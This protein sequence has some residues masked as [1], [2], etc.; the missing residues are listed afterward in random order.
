MHV[1]N[2]APVRTG[3][4][5]KVRDYAEGRVYCLVYKHKTDRELRVVGVYA[6]T[7][8]ELGKG[9]TAREAWTKLA[10]SDERRTLQAIVGLGDTG[11]AYRLAD[12]ALE[13]HRYV[14]VAYRKLTMD[15]AG[16]WRR[17]VVRG[18]RV[19]AFCAR[20]DACGCEVVTR[21]AEVRPE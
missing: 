4:Y 12:R 15:G 9:G 3:L 19:E 5:Q 1:E 11:L 8:C 16:P 7:H 6:H 18:D 10:G 17:K 20:Q 13:S 14:E 21:P 2:T